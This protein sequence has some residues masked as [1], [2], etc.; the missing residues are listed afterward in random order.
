LRKSI[1]GVF[2]ISSPASV[3]MLP[4]TPHAPPTSAAST[5]ADMDPYRVPFWFD[6]SRAPTYRLLNVGEETL[7]GVTAALNGPGLMPAL[8]PSTLE[9]QEALELVIRGDDLARE[10]SLTVAWMRPDGRA[11]L[12]QV[13]F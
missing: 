4:P 7:R 3:S 13:V 2:V 8:S 5:V 11:Y 10:T 12:W 6:R 1:V 9:P